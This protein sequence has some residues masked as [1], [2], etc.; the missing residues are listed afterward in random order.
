[1]LADLSGYTE[2][3]AASEPEHAPTMAGDLVEAVVRQLRPAFAL[4]K[5]E[6]DAAF[7]LAPLAD[8][9]GARLLDAIDADVRRLQPAGGEPEAGDDLRLRVLP[10]RSGP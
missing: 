9:D 1:M 7:L 3:V 10:P 5:L 8:L 4:E 2:Y 6:G